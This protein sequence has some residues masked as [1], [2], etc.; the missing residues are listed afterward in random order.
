MTVLGIDTSLLH[1]VDVHHKAIKRFEFCWLTDP[2]PPNVLNVSATT[3]VFGWDKVHF[4]G[5]STTKVPDTVLYTLEVAE[6]VEWKPGVASK[7][8]S[9]LTAT[10]FRQICRSPSCAAVV[11]EGLRPGTWYHARVAVEY[12]GVRVVSESL[13]CHTHRSTPKPPQRPRA[14]II[15]VASAT[16]PTVDATPQVLL[17]WAAPPANGGSTITAYQVQFKESVLESV[18]YPS[19]QVT[20]SPA[21]GTPS[22]ALTAALMA[23]ARAERAE[24]EAKIKMKSKAVKKALSNASAQAAN[25]V[26]EASGMLASNSLTEAKS[27]TP[28]SYQQL[29]ITSKWTVIYYNLGNKLRLS[30]PRTGTVAWH[31][32]VRAK[33]AEGWSE[34][35]PE[36]I[37]NG[38][39]LPS[40]FTTPYES[41]APGGRAGPPFPE[42]SSSPFQTRGSFL[43]L[44]PNPAPLRLSTIR[45]LTGTEG[46]EPEISLEYQQFDEGG[47]HANA[48]FSLPS[49]REKKPRPLSAS[50]AGSSSRMQPGLNV[51]EGG[52]N[53]ARGGDLD[54]GVGDRE[55]LQGL[56]GLSTGS[57]SRERGT[58]APSRKSMAM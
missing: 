13:S 26:Y 5:S 48:T 2:V 55:E 39:S 22:P 51:G 40:L 27:F 38:L 23:K 56:S 37:M 14:Y 24:K 31:F 54:S 32:R 42:E 4:C 16:D 44:A 45:S 18:A 58:S 36:L 10:N 9:D 47:E 17:T 52:M 46:F 11:V 43:G 21:L 20:P 28:S 25:R 41:I 30:A 34:F 49:T 12:A 8:I 6:G 50:E 29:A 57:K 1:L 3:L 33:N 35:S 7:F 19:N 53:S 15:P